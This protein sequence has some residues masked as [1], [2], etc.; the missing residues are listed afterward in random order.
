MTIVANVVLFPATMEFSK[1]SYA[2]T[3]LR[4]IILQDYFFPV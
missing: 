2:L 3:K 4:P 1:I